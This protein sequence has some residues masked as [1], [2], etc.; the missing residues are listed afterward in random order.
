MST[1]AFLALAFLAQDPAP[2]PVSFHRDVRPLLQASCTGCHQPARDRGGVVLVR[3]ADLVTAQGEEAP[4]VAPGAPDESLLLE[5]LSPFEDVPPAMPKDAA[6]LPPAAVALVRRWI[7]EGAVDDSPAAVQRDPG[8]A[9]VYPCAP[10]VT[11]LAFSPIGALLAVAGRGEV[12]LHR[13]DGS[14]LVARLVG[15]SERVESIAFSPDGARLAVAGGTPGEGGELQ[16]WRV[17]G[18]AL[19]LS[20]PV[21]HD[22]LAGLSWSPDGAL[23]AFGCKDETVRAHD[24]QS[25]APVLYQKAHEDWVL[26]TAFSTDGTHLVSVGRDRSL[27]LVKIETQQFIDNITSITPGA[28]RGG[29]MC[30]AR[31]PLRDELLVGGADGR[32]RVYRMFREQKRV[33]GDDYNLLVAFEPLL[34]RVYSAAW[35]PDGGRVVAGS[36]LE[37]R[38]EVRLVQVEGAATLWSRPLD[39][40]VYAVAYRPD[41]ALV[42]AAGFDGRVR[43]FDTNDG[44]LL[45]DF[46]PVPIL[47]PG[48]HADARSVDAQGGAQ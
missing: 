39:S 11:S 41:G 7:L 21:T 27:K 31:H 18:G 24:A 13:A 44:A 2:A 8:A 42:A 15:L 25:G 5:V 4:L 43:L 14:A 16:V 32:P 17:D 48:A 19:E 20:V 30:V 23:V 35:S 40:G 29:L 22:T 34:G 45:A 36:S 28:L 37:G 1:L 10:V 12:L 3:H 33:I 26:G 38:G 47:G 9:P 46:V 6:P